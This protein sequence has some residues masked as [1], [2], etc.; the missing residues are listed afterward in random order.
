MINRRAFLQTT[1]AAVGSDVVMPPE[2]FDHGTLHVPARPGLGIGL[3]DRI[4]RAKPSA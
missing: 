1:A 3:N 4:I 2:R